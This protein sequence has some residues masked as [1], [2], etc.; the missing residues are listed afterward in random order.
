M[1]KR[2]ASMFAAQGVDVDAPRAKRHKTSASS[3]TVTKE[4]VGAVNGDGSDEVVKMEDV[5]DDPVAVKEKGL[6]LWQTIK[7]AVNKEGRALSVDF[8]RLPSKRQYPDY[9]EQIKRPIALDD[10]KKELEAGGY[11]TFDEV[12][13]D[14]EQCFKNAKRYNIKE[15]QIWKDAK[16]LH[17]LVTKESNKLTGSTTEPADDNDGNGADGSDGE[18]EGGKK[19]KAPNMTRLLKSR[20]QKLVEK[21]DDDGRVLSG[22]FMELPNKKAWPQYYK[23]IKRPQCFENIF[24]HLKRKEYHNPLDFAND[25]ELV[26][27]NALEFNQEH[28]QIW[29]DTVLLRDYFRTLMSDLPSPYSI[30]AYASPDHSTKIKFKMPS[31]SLPAIGSTA[32]NSPPKSGGSPGTEASP[33][34][35]VPIPSPAP[36]A[37][38]ALAPLSQT[39]SFMSVMS[40]PAVGTPSTAAASSTILSP[41]V[42]AVSTPNLGYAAPAAASSAIGPQLSSFSQQAYAAAARRYAGAGQQPSTVASTSASTLP[43]TNNINPSRTTT[44]APPIPPVH[45]TPAPQLSRAPTQTFVQASKSPTPDFQ[46]RRQLRYVSII[47]KPFGRR[48]DLDHRDGVKTWAVRLG[49][50]ETS[51]HVGDVKFLAHDEDDESGDEEERRDKQKD[52]EAERHEEEEEEEDPPQQE[53]PKRGRGRPRKKPRSGKVA[54]ES[55]K[56]SKG[57]T[58]AKA[59]A[60]LHEEEVQMRLNGTLIDPLEDQEGEWEVNLAMGLNVLEVG[61]KDGIIWRVHL[62]RIVST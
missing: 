28:T 8:L 53:K 6:K 38:L 4:D 17:K 23:L 35:R 31:A 16:H 36:N 26:F 51:I 1:S 57:K 12:R 52:Q 14:F 43:N 9:Y 22:E 15:S 42:H 10:I 49:A 45:Q 24:K 20:L 46:N 44:Q 50:G 11:A 5:Q 21:T 47:T 37:T 13:Q 62:E 32:P 48:L 58:V 27:S 3:P 29:E 7:D 34:L 61:E 30:P 19:K 54:S 18:G 39:Q 40:P 25:V 59:A 33:K 56:A 2:E 55:P 41:L 60:A